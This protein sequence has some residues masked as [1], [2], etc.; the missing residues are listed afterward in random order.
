MFVTVS[1][2][3]GMCRNGPSVL[4]PF[5]SQAHREVPLRRMEPIHN[6]HPGSATRSSQLVA[7][8][9]IESLLERL[10]RETGVEDVETDRERH[11][12]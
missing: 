7:Q 5:V 9:F 4:N 1:T 11:D 6:H 2:T 3:R 8:R 12:G 10:E